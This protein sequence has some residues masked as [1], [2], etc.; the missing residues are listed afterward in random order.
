MIFLDFDGVLFDTVKEAYSISVISIKMHNNIDEINYDSEHYNLFRKYRYLISPAWNYKYLLE[1]LNNFKDNETLQQ[2]YLLKIKNTTKNEYEEFEKLFFRTRKKIKDQEFDKWLHLNQSFDFLYK[3]KPLL[4]KY[5]NLFYI[6]TT[7]DKETVLKLLDIEN[8][9]FNTTNIY[10][11]EDYSKYG[12]KKNIITTLVDNKKAI[13]VDDSLKHIKECSLIN[14]LQCLQPDWG[15][16]SSID[17]ALS[18][19]IILNK[20]K[21]HIKGNNV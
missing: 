18:E 16:V 8:I 14:N 12:S 4:I 15:Y 20:I 1:E 3:I 6:I 10:D 17:N 19:T 7:K 13:F 21:D 9:Q 5:S 2:N 11:K